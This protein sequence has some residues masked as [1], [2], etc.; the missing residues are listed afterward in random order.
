[1]SSA[2]SVGSRPAAVEFGKTF[3]LTLADTPELKARAFRLRCAV[4]CRELGFAMRQEEGLEADAY[5]GQSLHCLL[6]HRA[7]GED[8][9]CIR[10]VL[11]RRS[12]GGLPFE[13]FGLRYV[14]RSLLDWR[15][16]DSRLCCEV[17]RLAVCPNFRHRLAGETQAS[18]APVVAIS[19]YHS[20]I[21]L[22]LD[23]GYSH[24]FMVIEPRLGRHLKRYGI[25]LQQISPAFEH[26][27][28]RA[29][30]V[31]TRQQLLWEVNHW[32]PEWRDVYEDVHRQLLARPAT[33]LQ[34]LG[35]V[36]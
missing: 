24:V 34:L 1:M 11:P 31:T 23:R 10:L 36:A 2:I 14:D 20:V 33:P 25:Q 27:G 18:S 32:R 9:G 29:T 6:T 17:S 21:A 3:Q 8:V 35:T 22:I 26:Y 5:D 30:F 16:L 28:S 13:G 7:S 19:L 12:G 4:F 15:Q